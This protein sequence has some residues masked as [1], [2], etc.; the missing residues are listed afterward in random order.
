MGAGKN[1]YGTN[2]ENAHRLYKENFPDCPI[3]EELKFNRISHD[4]CPFIVRR[5]NPCNEKECR[6]VKWDKK[7]LHKMDIPKKCRRHISHYCR[8]DN[9]TYTDPIC[10]CWKVENRNLKKCIKLREKYE[11]AT[12]YGCNINVFEIEEHPD[13]KN[14]IRKD[15]IPCWNCDL[16]APAAKDSVIKTRNWDNL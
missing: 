9:N 14:Y 10:E 7:N 15:K 5:A 13:F 8:I 16:T 12:D 4:K 1:S 2:K 3:P 11:P 6:N